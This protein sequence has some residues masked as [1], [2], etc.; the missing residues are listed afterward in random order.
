MG[1]K[2]GGEQPMYVSIKWNSD[3]ILL[4]TKIKKY[5]SIWKQ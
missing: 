4:M 3:Y 1:K 2:T 5:A